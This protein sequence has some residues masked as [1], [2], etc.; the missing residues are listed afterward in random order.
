MANPATTF[1]RFTAKEYLE[2]ERQAASKHEFVDGLVYAMAGAGRTHN[3]I[4]GNVFARLHAGVRPPCNA[5][6]SDMKVWVKAVGFEHFFYPDAH[7]TCSDLDRDPQFNE[8]P[9]LIVEVLSDS[10]EIYDRDAK[11]EHYKR[12]PSLQEY[13]L[14]Q[15]GQPV[16]ELYRKRTGLQKELY[17]ISDGMTLESVQLTLP[18][19]ALY[20]RVQF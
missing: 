12:L 19:A 3:S 15:H 4:A 16:A 7:V 20:E 8:R 1:P 2:I 11:F 18:I 17:S 9:I 10:T 6:N 14:L 5:F 13:L